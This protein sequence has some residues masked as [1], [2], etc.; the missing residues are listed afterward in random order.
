MA[1]LTITAA[2]IGVGSSAEIR[3]V[4]VG[5]S[6][7][8]GIPLYQ[9]TSDGLWKPA[10]ADAEATAKAA[11][12]SVTSATASGEDVI[13]IFT[14]DLRMGAILTKGTEYYVNTTAGLIGEKSDLGSGDYVTRLGIAKSTSVLDVR[15]LASGVT[16]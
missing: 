8:H 5:Q 2:N 12:I 10:D 4:T 11:C 7:A 13:A 16:L 3:P 1:T 9:D 6:T 14:G 15:P